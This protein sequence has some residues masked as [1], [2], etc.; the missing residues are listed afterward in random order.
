MV[1]NLLLWAVDTVWSLRERQ[2]S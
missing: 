2:G 1:K